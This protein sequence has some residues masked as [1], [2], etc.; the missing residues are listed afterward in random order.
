M[1]EGSLRRTVQEM[2]E[3]IDQITEILENHEQRWEEDS[4]VAFDPRSC[5]SLVQE[6]HDDI[7]QEVNDEAGK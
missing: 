5:L 4:S 2:Q 1:D 3:K 7:N 6:L